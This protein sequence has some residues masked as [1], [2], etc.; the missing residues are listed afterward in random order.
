MNSNFKPASH[1]H[2]VINQFWQ[3]FFNMNEE[4]VNHS[5]KHPEIAID[6]E[7]FVEVCERIGF[8]TATAEQIEKVFKRN[9][10]HNDYR[11]K[12]LVSRIHH[13]PMQFLVF[14]RVN[15]EMNYLIASED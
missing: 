11:R 6:I 2:P 9:K 12:N 5:S 8:E 15:V 7:Q 14:Y 1:I 3:N 4:F 13:W 10:F